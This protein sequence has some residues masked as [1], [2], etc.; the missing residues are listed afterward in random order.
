VRR[1]LAGVLALCL[2]ITG[3]VFTPAHAEGIFLIRDSEV[4]QLMR[5]YADPVFRAAGLTPSDV[6][7][8]LI[9]EN[10]INAFVA[11]G[12]R[13]FIHTGLLLQSTSPSEVIGVLAHEAGHIAGG[14][15]A[16]LRR[17]LDRASTAA[18]VSMLIGAAAIVGGV[19]AG[20]SGTAQAGQGVLLGGGNAVQRSL[21]SYQ[22]A[23]EASADQAAISYL[24]NSGL[25]ARGMLTLFEKLANQSLVSLQFA[26]PYVMSHPMPRQ[27]IALLEQLAGQSPF[28]DKEDPIELVFR[29]QM[30]QAKLYG[31]LLD[32]R[33]T[34]Q[35]YPTSDTTQQAR[36][37]RSIAYYRSG[38]LTNSLSEIDSLITETPD[39]PYFWEVRGQA[40]FETGQAAQSIEPLSRAAELAPNAPQIRILLAQAM[41][42][43]DDALYADRAIEHLKTAFR[44]EGGSVN[45]HRQLAFAYSAKGNIGMAELESAEAAVLSGDL[46]LAK[47]FAQRARDKL[48]RGTPQYV[49]ASDILRLN[50]DGESN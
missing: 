8:H 1:S 47:T 19:A 39:N 44:L 25:S 13:V 38:E 32:P 17:Q 45:L 26:D 22:R 21:L 20:S 43:T 36:Y 23:Q 14:H 9:A 27:R 41:L 10:S 3:S 28:F 16:R 7:V 18:L 33:E 48:E 12:Q 31:Y 37:A 46:D 5:D 4:E 2:A 30:M 49:R 11:G 29:H 34:L 6:R 42:G 40:L 50:A 15:L 24:D 35:R